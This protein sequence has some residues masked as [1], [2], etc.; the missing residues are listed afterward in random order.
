V[1]EDRIQVALADDDVLLREGLASLLERSGFDVVGQSADARLLLALV[2]ERQPELVIVDIRMPPTHSTEGLEAARQIRAEFPDIAILVL[3]AHVEV[4]HA[5]GLLASGQRSGY[6]LK[7]RV[8]DVDDFIDTLKRLVKGASVVDPAL[9]AELVTARHAD[10]QLDVLS[11]REREVL[12]LMA[13]GRS[14]SGIARKLWVTEGTVEKH[15][16]SILTKLRL[17]EADDMH[18]R[19]LA[20]LTFLNERL[21][22]L[23]EEPPDAIRRKL[24]L[25]QEAERAALDDQLGIVVG[26]VR[27]DHDDRQVSGV[28]LG[29]LACEIE[30]VFVTEHDIDE[31]HIWP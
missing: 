6:L 15:I 23:A 28:T 2:R 11:P 9:V 25:R 30:T 18:R 29:E 5:T 17:P 7:S 10:D 4:E 1:T 3:S 26:G 13:E 8:I 12:S 31:N 21:A 16:G 27:R 22:D 19:V 20:V 14:N 24:G